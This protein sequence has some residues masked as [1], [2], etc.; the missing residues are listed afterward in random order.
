VPV[1]GFTG[2]LQNLSC[3]CRKDFD[4]LNLGC[5]RSQEDVLIDR[6][7]LLLNQGL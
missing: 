3:R 7:E 1:F 4:Q 2:E 6:I 5:G